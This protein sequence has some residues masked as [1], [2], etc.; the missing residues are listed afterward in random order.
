M[1]A[2]RIKNKLSIKLG[3]KIKFV[4]I[5]DNELVGLVFTKKIKWLGGDLTK[6]DNYEIILSAS[7]LNETTTDFKYASSVRDSLLEVSRKADKMNGVIEDVVQNVGQMQGT[8]DNATKEINNANQ[9]LIGKLDNVPS[10]D[11]L[12]SLIERVEKLQTSTE[13]V[14]KIVETIQVNGV[15]KVTTETGVTVDIKGMHIDQS[16]AP[17][18]QTHDAYGQT[19]IDKSD[20]SSL[21][22]A[23]YDKETQETIVKAKNMTVEKYLNI[24]RTRFEAYENPRFGKATGA[25]FIDN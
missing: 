20:G 18:S 8:I 23:G 19:I 17:V 1:R 21:L 15:D 22:F 12:V 4:D 9:D 16:D 3:Q 13:S 10:K 25:F 5:W 14:T 6:D 24:P 7:K 2:Q 11:D